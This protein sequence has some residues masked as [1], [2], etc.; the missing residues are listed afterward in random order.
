MRFLV[1]DANGKLRFESRSWPMARSALDLVIQEAQEQ[2]PPE[3]FPR[4][5]IGSEKDILRQGD[6][7]IS[8]NEAL[9]AL[10]LG[11]DDAPL[12]IQ[13]T[14]MQCITEAPGIGSKEG[15]KNQ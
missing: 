8:R 3:N 1:Y 15:R 5:F 4:L 14:A 13:A 6:D 10:R 2:D 11:L 9:R 12:Y 7:C